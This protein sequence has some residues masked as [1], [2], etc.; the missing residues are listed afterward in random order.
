M[1]HNKMHFSSYS[2]EVYQAINSAVKLSE[3]RLTNSF[4][5]RGIF[6]FIDENY[7]GL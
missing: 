6:L 3:G 7:M 1:K 2:K 4:G 5:F